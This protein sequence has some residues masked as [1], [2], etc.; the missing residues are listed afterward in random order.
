MDS[1]ETI[2]DEVERH[3]TNVRLKFLAEGVRQPR[4]PTHV[5]HPLPD[6]GSVVARYEMIEIDGVR[7][8]NGCAI[9]QAEGV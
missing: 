9:E 3:R 7:R 4:E 6:G 5:H 1:A 8:I 2:I